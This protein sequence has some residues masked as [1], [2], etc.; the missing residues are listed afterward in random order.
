MS[1]SLADTLTQL[2]AAIPTGGR[3]V[4]YR[5]TCGCE[6]EPGPLLRVL[7]SAA[8][9]PARQWF[10]LVDRGSSGEDQ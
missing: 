3:R 6:L 4:V 1:V 10:G 9:P 5:V 8:A 2:A 7:R